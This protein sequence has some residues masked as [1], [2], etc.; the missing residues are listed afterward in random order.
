MNK[1]NKDTPPLK[2][3]TYNTH[4]FYHTAPGFFGEE[5]ED[6]ERINGIIDH[7]RTSGADVVGLNEVWA[8]STKETFIQNLRIQFPYSYYNPN[9]EIFK[10]GSGLLFLSKYPI[11]NPSFVKFQELI[12]WD[13]MSQKGMITGNIIV[14]SGGTYVPYFFVITHTQ[15]GGS[16]DEINVRHDNI[17]QMWKVIRGLPFGNNPLVVFGDLNVIAENEGGSITADYY[18]LTS[19]LGSLGLKD[20]YRVIHPSAQ[21]DHGY[22]S[23]WYT[24]DLKKIFNPNDKTRTRLDY[25]FV[26]NFDTNN[27]ASS[28]ISVI[29]NYTY[30]DPKTSEQMD[31]SD[32]FP[33]I[34]SATVV[35]V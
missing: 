32:H 30:Y 31:L 11:I 12:G 25:F 16:N 1:D 8:D 33:L 22:T 20:L 34:A 13:S 24:N 9:K 5:Y 18:Y 15:A 14:P 6:K 21:Q 4:L 17:D 35:I 2:F 7:L 26:K 27:S 3:V 29:H 28:T 23:D 10:L 19:M